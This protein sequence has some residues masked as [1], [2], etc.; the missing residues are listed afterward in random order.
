MCRKIFKPILFCFVLFIQTISAYSIGELD[1]SGNY[2]FHTLSPDGGFY[3]DGVKSIKQDQTGFIWIVMDNEVYRFDGYQYK[4]YYSRFKGL[5]TSGNWYFNAVDIDSSGQIFIASDNG[6][7]RYNQTTDEFDKVFN[8]IMSSAFID[9][10]NDI[11]V[12]GSALGRI[13]LENDT[14]IPLTFNGKKITNINAFSQLSDGLLLGTYYGQIYRFDY[15]KQQ[16]NL[17]YQLPGKYYILGIEQK[18]SSLWVLTTI[19]GLFELEFNTG[20]I[21]RHFDFFCKEQGNQIVAKT[22]H[23]DPNNQLWIGTQRGLYILNPEDEQ[24]VL[25]K[26]SHSDTF[27][28]PDN[29]V[30]T[31]EEDHQHNLWIG[32]YG[33]GL[34]YVDFREQPAFKSYSFK[35]EELNHNV[36]S[37]FCEGERSIWVATEGGGINQIDKGTGIFSYF[38]H[39]Q[40]Q[41]SLSSN[42]IKSMVLDCSNR[43]W[44]ATFRGGL[45]CY[46]LTTNSFQSMKHKQNN[47]NSLITNDLKKIVAEGDSGLWIVYQHRTHLI[48]FYSFKR[49]KLEHFRFSDLGGN[50]YIF[51]IC[52][53]SENDL[54]LVTHNSLF[55][56]DVK[57]KCI[58]IIPNEVTDLNGQSLCVGPDKKVW[59]GTIG[60][61][62]VCFDPQN[63]AFQFFPAILNYNVS[64][65]YSLCWGE[66][67]KLWIGTD[68]GLFSY[69]PKENQFSRFDKKDGLQGSVFYPLASMKMSSGELYFGGTNGFSIVRPDKVKKNSFLPKA[70]ITDL[71]IDN[72]SVQPA[73]SKSP[74]DRVITF[75]D[76]IT[77][78][79]TQSNFGF[80]FSSDSYLIP[81]KNRFKYRMI[82]Y[83]DRWVETS[84]SNRSALYSKVPPGDYWFEVVASNND[85][86]WG[87]IPA[88]IRIKRLPAPW[89]STFAYLIYIF[90]VLSI[91]GLILRYYYQQ[92]KL[93]MQLFLEGI[94]KSKNEE[95]H[96]AQLRFFTNISH[97]F[98]TPLS[99]IIATLS[100]IKQDGGYS[101]FYQLLNN[102]AQRLLR[103]V[104][105]LMDF[106][107]VENDKMKVHLSLLSV[108]RLIQGISYDFQDYAMQR[109]IIFKMICSPELDNEIP[110]DK[111]IFEKVIINLLHNAFKY[112]PEGRKITIE[113]IAQLSD[114]HSEYEYNFTL[115]DQVNDQPYFAIIIRDTGVGISSESI[116]KVFERFYKVEEK[117]GELHLGSGVGLA[118]VK[119]LVLLHQGIIRICS[120]RGKG[121]DMLVAFLKNKEIYNQ[122]GF[123]IESTIEKTEND[124]YYETIKQEASSIA[125]EYLPESSILLREKK[126]ILL[127]EDNEELRSLVA[128]FLSASFDIIEA[129]NGVE[130]AEILDNKEIDLI[131][132]D[133]MMPLKDGITLCREVKSD[134]NI[135]HIPFLLLTAKCS[136]D[137]KIEGAE[138]G[139]DIYFEKP[140]D[141][142]LLL[143]SI[144]NLFLRQHRLKEHYARNYY[145]DSSELT[146]NAQD[147]KFLKK[148]GEIIEER[149]NQPEMDVNSIAAELSMSRGKLYTKLRSI[150]DKSIVEFI[151]SYRLRKAARL[152]VDENMPLRD[153]MDQIG[154]ESQSYFTRAF[155]KEFG[156]TPSSFV[157]KYRKTVNF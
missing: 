23:R 129:S 118:L 93:K 49:K 5:E 122:L 140:I 149:M 39:E 133:I 31:I 112:T 148:L 141:L 126:R 28:L 45:D 99:L 90:I 150:T 76:K 132:S 4:R 47:T 123:L 89:L 22:L 104:N 111:N 91:I 82:G 52:K 17:L 131:V 13:N 78:D 3:Y 75:I 34:C 109:N 79:Y 35:G 59:I 11:W 87:N 106:R 57:T 8:G 143:L 71:F 120:E 18:G 6:L 30:W 103:L 92:K 19:D 135:S 38:R 40:N 139:A 153:V 56:V 12:R 44:I 152:M 60:N 147:N 74:I 88:R 43:L 58:S 138:C 98:R 97:D 1:V 142:Q 94:E 63:K 67:N 42:N 117:E 101:H 157:S 108:N 155:K 115:G 25:Y 69:S 119:S 36:V 20:K 151:L 7:F 125:E 80:G 77:L 68:N 130:A 15:K 128:S 73:P 14:I 85:G 32:T 114:F 84:A 62:L 70:V 41:N 53:G 81:G 50:N 29:S 10:R 144:Q 154:I 100:K 64:S 72:I 95:I 102:N 124:I 55:H 137:S 54:W 61:G 27:G 83:D 146:S 46:N 136:I 96:Q 9:N 33:G 65:I 86:V 66:N 110:I 107:A 24:Y 37:G 116:E 21:I 127:V 16:L 48:S 121:T 51:D 26:Q 145:V 156:E 105:E 134:I 2:I 113:T